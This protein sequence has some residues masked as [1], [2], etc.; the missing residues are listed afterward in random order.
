MSSNNWTA[1]G[2]ASRRRRAHTQV[3]R[4]SPTSIPLVQC[5]PDKKGFLAHQERRC[6]AALSAYDSSPDTAKA[7]DRR[8]TCCR[9]DSS[10]TCFTLP[11]T[12]S[13][14]WSIRKQYSELGA[15]LPVTGSKNQSGSSMSYRVAPRRVRLPPITSSAA[16]ITAFRAADGMSCQLMVG[17]V[18]R[19]RG[20]FPPRRGGEGARDGSVKLSTP[21]RTC[22]DR[23]AHFLAWSSARQRTSD[24]DIA[25]N[26]R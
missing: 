1:P 21:G 16:A 22:W 4:R 23:Q 14:R 17:S 25:R 5:T 7:A 11:V 15:V 26:R 19:N 3:M 13:D 10:H 2:H 24:A 9:R 20:P 18:A 8:E 6:D 12:S